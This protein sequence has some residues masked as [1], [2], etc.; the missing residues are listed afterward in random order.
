[1]ASTHSDA[2]VLFGASGDL[3]YKQIFPALLSLARK[4]HLN[5]PVIGVARSNWNDDQ[6]RE[7]VRSSL[8][9]HGP[10]DASAFER[11]AAQ[12]KYVSG[13]YESEP[14]F[15]RLREKLG[16][17]VHPLHFL[18][19]PPSMFGTVAANLG[20][21][22]CAKEARVLVE[23]PLGRDL[24]SAQELN[25]L[26]LTYFPESAIYRIDHYMGK[27]AVQ[28][29]LYFRFSNSF[30]EPIW[31]SQF[32]D[33]V[34]I[35]MAE[36][37]GVRGRG[38]FY[39]EVGAIRD[40]VQNHM[41][42][43][44]VLL[45]MDSPASTDTESLRDERIRVLRSMR[46]LDKNEVVRGQFKGYRDETDVAPES[47]VETFAALRFH[48]DNWRW[49]GVPFCIRVGK[50]LPLTATEVFVT[51]KRPPYSVFG[52]VVPNQSNFYR[53]RLSPEVVVSLGARV[54]TPG[55]MVGDDVELIARHLPGR[56]RLPYERLISDAMHGDQSLF[57]REDA[58]EA[59]WR[60]IDP[61][62]SDAPP[63]IEY[64]PNTWG[65]KEADKVVADM[66]G[67]H[68]P[69]SQKVV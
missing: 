68:N 12:L 16:N 38:K 51:L 42:Q 69:E 54:K 50:E 57:N 23:K 63:V 47:Q 10:F 46:P 34:Q 24:A 36:D 61:I 19:I 15:Q 32:V 2:F 43:V 14:T 40:V 8:Q 53:F 35:T 4:D 21:S 6:L 26:L 58:V 44:T 7:R 48:I 52:E 39:E 11:L 18:A 59:A 30:L 65:P 45:A 67:W 56:D 29:L 20:K 49:A 66:G 9:E 1:M 64:E 33:S 60:V 31:N 17:A 13:D 55:E 62:L 28:N 3:A 22:G 5:L 37:F 41:L 25:K 27:E